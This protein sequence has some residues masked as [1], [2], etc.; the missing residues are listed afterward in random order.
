MFIPFCVQSIPVLCLHTRASGDHSS[1]STG[2]IHAGA[3]VRGADRGFLLFPAQ[4]LVGMGTAHTPAGTGGGDGTGRCVVF[5]VM[6]NISF[7]WQESQ[8]TPQ[9]PGGHHGVLPGCFWVY[10]GL[11]C[12]SLNDFLDRWIASASVTLMDSY[13]KHRSA[14]LYFWGISIRQNIFEI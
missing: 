11:E 4:F 9:S 13:M 8:R 14:N 7:A 3:F 10:T 6:E 2:F 12:I 5:V 1:F